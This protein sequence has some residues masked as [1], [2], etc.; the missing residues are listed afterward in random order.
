MSLALPWWEENRVTPK[1]ENGKERPKGSVRNSLLYITAWVSAHCIEGVTDQE[2]LQPWAHAF[3]L[4]GQSPH[5]KNAQTRPADLS[6]SEFL[7]ICTSAGEHTGDA[8]RFKLTSALKE[9]N[10]VSPL[11]S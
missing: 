4:I 10:P 11:L 2:P 1:A 8:E 6:Y 3:P 9:F 7:S 5:L